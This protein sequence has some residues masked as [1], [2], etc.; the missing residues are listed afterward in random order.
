MNMNCLEI[1]FLKI[2]YAL[3]LKSASDVDKYIAMIHSTWLQKRPSWLI[4]SVIIYSNIKY[5]GIYY[6]YIYINT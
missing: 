1:L 3:S 6:I 4:C 2:G 5:L